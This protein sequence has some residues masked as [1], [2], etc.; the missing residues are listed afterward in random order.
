MTTLQKTDTTVRTQTRTAVGDILLCPGQGAQHVGMG[1][2]W[3]DAD[4]EARAT[5]E[6]ADDLLGE[7]AGARLSSLCFEGPAE[8]LNRTDIAQAAIY[9]CS[10]AAYRSLRR[11]GLLAEGRIVATA[12]LS[13]GEFTALHLAGA[14]S[15]EDGLKLV[16]LRGQ[17]MQDAAEAVPSGMVALIGAEQEQAETLCLEVLGRVREDD[18]VLVPANF[19][20]PQQVVISGSRAACE[21]A[22]QVAAELGLAAKPL[23]VAGAFHSPIMQPAAHRLAKALEHTDWREP[24]VPVLSN[25]TGQPHDSANVEAIK[26]LL[27]EQLSRPVQWAK[28]MT[29]SNMHLTGRYVEL[30]PGKVLS[31]LMRRIDRRRDV[32]NF[33]EAPAEA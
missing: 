5:F 27:V 16:R 9:V 33:A 13:L 7:L 4:A 15:F 18:P 22:V 26:G 29:W 2:S 11:R 32:L 30:S 14:F 17:A 12:G 31:G 20:C 3:Y 10:V 1:K 23:A 24:R 25:V 28:S 21:C 6:A 8:Q 19:N